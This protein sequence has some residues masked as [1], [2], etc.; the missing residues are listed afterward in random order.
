[1]TY[2]ERRGGSIWRNN[3]NKSVD[4]RE[5]V[6]EMGPGIWREP[7]KLIRDAKCEPS[8]LRHVVTF[9]GEVADGCISLSL[10]A[11]EHLK[12]LSTGGWTSGP[13]GPQLQGNNSPIGDNVQKKNVTET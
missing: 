4:Q 7:L 2:I 10:I 3:V 6:R 9:Q 13:A 12:W 11:P 8:T 5:F 1:M